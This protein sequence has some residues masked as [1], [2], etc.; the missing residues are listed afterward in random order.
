MRERFNG[1]RRWKLRRKMKKG[2][3][4]FLKDD[5]KLI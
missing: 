3:K 4:K 2:K 1:E 5:K